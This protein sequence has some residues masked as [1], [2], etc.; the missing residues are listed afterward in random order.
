[1]ELKSSKTPL[2]EALKEI[3]TLEPNEVK[4]KLSKNLCN[5]IDIRDIS[6]LEAEGK[7]KGTQHI[8]MENLESII[9]NTDHP[10]FTEGKI[11]TEKEIIL[12]CASGVRSVFAT[13]SLKDKG[14]KNISQVRGGFNLMCEEGFELD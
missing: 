13:K 4:E 6:E 7:L 10:L 9:L 1:M 2:E 3:K 14:L 5:L 8:P 12:F 11:D